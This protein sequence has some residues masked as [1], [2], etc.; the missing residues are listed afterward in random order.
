[1]TLNTLNL[2]GSQIAY[3]YAI[4]S[5]RQCK[6]NVIQRVLKYFSCNL[7]IFI[8]AFFESISRIS[9]STTKLELKAHQTEHY[10]IFPLQRSVLPLNTFSDKLFIGL[11]SWQIT[12]MTLHVSFYICLLLSCPTSIKLNIWW[13]LIRQNCWIAS[14]VFVNYY[15]AGTL[16]QIVKFIVLEW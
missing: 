1:M 14:C 3:I 7:F 13:S 6:L 9:Y 2:N 5:L 11:F 8:L 12:N 15:H 10:S 16:I 4:L